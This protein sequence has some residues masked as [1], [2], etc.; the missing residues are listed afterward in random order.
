MY[1]RRYE[2]VFL[3]LRQE[4]AGYALGKRQP[5]GSCVM[6]MKNGQGKLC[7]TMQGLKP[8]R[9]AVYVMA[10]AESIFCGEVFPDK[11]EG[12][13]ELKWAFDPDRIGEGKT[14]EDLHTVIVLAEGTSAPLTAYFR[15]KRDW[16]RDF[17]P[18]DG[19]LTAAELPQTAETK[20]QKEGQRQEEK[21]DPDTKSAEGQEERYHGSFQ[22]LL[23]KF[24]R[25]L[26]ELEETEVLSRREV[27]KI[28]GCDRDGEEPADRTEVENAEKWE[29]SVFRE[30]QEMSPFA[31]GERW[32]RIS[33]EETVLL[34]Q[35]PLRWQKEHFFLLP[36]RK[37]HHLILRETEDGIWL[38][39]PGQFCADDAAEALQ[40][41]FREFRN[42]EEPWGYW[43]TFLKRN[44]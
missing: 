29:D 9:Y 1:N 19:E 37:Y 23:A 6:E 21:M 39:L 17:R 36:Y 14:A 10:G 41:G 42:T 12:R 5:W 15:E 16:R 24:R 26:K 8:L 11:K 31:D 40:F 25:E 32:K 43:M 27:E 38:G 7:L 20:E 2:K 30:K 35:I 33:P 34:P 4:T 22:G 28:C 18:A 13:C 44:S 3:M